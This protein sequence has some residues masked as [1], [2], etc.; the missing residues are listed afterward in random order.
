MYS[1]QWEQYLSFQGKELRTGRAQKS[2]LTYFSSYNLIF[3]SLVNFSSVSLCVVRL[4]SWAG[5]GNS[6]DF[7]SLVRR[8][9]NE[10]GPE[11]FSQHCCVGPLVQCTSVAMSCCLGS[12]ASGDRPIPTFEICEVLKIEL[13]T[14]A[15]SRHV[16]SAL[17]YLPGPRILL[18]SGTLEKSK[19]AC[20]V[21]LLLFVSLILKKNYLII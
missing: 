3:L 9:E 14:Y 17:T 15:H 11:L 4:W 8:Q 6:C 21:L 1:P 12:M 19:V 16:I 20:S 5:S 18:V 10:P 13:S 2:F 7:L